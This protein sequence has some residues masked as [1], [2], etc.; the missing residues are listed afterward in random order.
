MGG[1]EGQTLNLMGGF[2]DGTFRPDESVTF[3]QAVTILMRM[4]GYR[5]AD[6][7]MNWPRSYLSRAAAIKLTQG[8][9]LAD[10]APVTRANGM[11]LFRNLLYA[12]TY[13]GGK[14]DKEFLFQRGATE[15]AD[16]IL[17]NPDAKA[18]DG[19]GKSGAL[20]IAPAGGA[21]F[22][23]TRLPLDRSLLW[24]T[25]RLILGEDGVVVVFEP[26]AQTVRTVLV[27]SAAATALTTD[28]GET[29]TVPAAAKLYRGAVGEE[30]SKA[31]A[32]LLPRQSVRVVFDAAGTVRHLLVD[33]VAA[34]DDVAV[35]AAPIRAGTDPTEVLGSFARGAAIYKNGYPA[36]VADLCQYDAL[37]YDANTRTVYAS[38]SRIT[39]LYENCEGSPQAPSSITVG[40]QTFAMSD[41]A[42]NHMPDGVK[43]G[44]R[45]TVLFAY[46]GQVAGVYE[47][48][49]IPSSVGLLNSQ[50]T[51][52]TTFGG[53]EF[54][55]KGSH[56]QSFGQLATV[57][58]N[59]TG[60]LIA[61]SIGYRR[62][63]YAAD[64]DAMTMGPDGIAAHCVFYERAG[65]GGHLTQIQAGD[66]PRRVPADRIAHA[67]YD[68]NNRVNVLVVQ[69]LTGAGYKYGLA[70]SGVTVEGDMGGYEVSTTTLTMADGSVLKLVNNPPLQGVSFSGVVG[71]MPV[72]KNTDTAVGE[73]VS[74]TRHSGLKPADFEGER[75]VRIG[76]V[77]YAVAPGVQVYFEQTKTFAT[78]ADA[79]LRAGSFEAY[80]DK[81]AAQGGKVRFLIAK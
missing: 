76:G 19:S 60:S 16:V 23:E 35:I 61:G 75:H 22:Y 14:E 9:A 32:N 10:N 13:A 55:V 72:W 2:P 73:V 28:S 38:D 1:A 36:A 37:T 39:G 71:L 54:A 51:A 42:R 69:G 15:K 79:R 66:L 68:S 8:V 77:R 56:E 64:L 29:I 67:G 44:G 57:S 58:S 25:G 27:G 3:A 20:F 50:G 46:G 34:S 24:R 80:T 62:G 12:K 26:A 30:Y 33:D 4:L 41:R 40:G 53:L 17:L 47:Q 45:V 31:Q 78:I 5:D 65:E 7:G 48:G 52:V 70:T 11:L 81:P 74:T 6:V 49:V 43:L 59:L 18:S 63:T 21:E